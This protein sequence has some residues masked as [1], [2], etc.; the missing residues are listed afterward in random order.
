MESFL[1][2]A[3][4]IKSG[5]HSESA[6]R[7]RLSVGEFKARGNESHAQGD[8]G[9]QGLRWFWRTTTLGGVTKL[10][11]QSSKILIVRKRKDDLKRLRVLSIIHSCDWPF[12]NDR[13]LL[14]SSANDGEGPCVLYG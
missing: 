13:C 8:C 4:P 10:V 7:E 5:D 2:E 3:F 6:G 14:L 1:P 11:L 12:S 9:I